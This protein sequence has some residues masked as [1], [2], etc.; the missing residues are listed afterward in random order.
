MEQQTYKSSAIENVATEGYE[1]DHPPDVYI[2]FSS[3]KGPSLEVYL[4]FEDAK[5]LVEMLQRT[6]R[7]E[8][9]S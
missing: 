4:S 1:G 9:S 5:R 6:I 8:S 7:E 3:E 2:T